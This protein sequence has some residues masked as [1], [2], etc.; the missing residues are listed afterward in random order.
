MTT[1]TLAPMRRPLRLLTIAVVALGLLAPAALA[2]SSPEPGVTVDPSSPSAK[3]YALPVDKARKDAQ[4]KKSSKKKD[5]SQLFGAGVK[6]SGGS[7]TS[8]PAPATAT[9]APAATTAKPPASSSK[10]SKSK[11]AAKREKARKAAAAKRKKQRERAI[12]AAAQKQ[13]TK[14]NDDQAAAIPVSSA[15]A[16]PA[17]L[18]PALVI[19]VG[20][21][22]VL[23]LGGL[24]GLVLKRRMSP[25]S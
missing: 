1:S 21:L 9:P 23:L 14:T 15:S 4:G 18:G 19:A 24:T 3:E 11:A 22:G 16:S 13:T 6:P 5:D 20:G 10:T 8:T 25:D 17:G 12:A 2:Q 7:G